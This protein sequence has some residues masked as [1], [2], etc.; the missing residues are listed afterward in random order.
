LIFVSSTTG[1]NSDGCGSEA[2][3]CFSI[4]YAIKTSARGDTIALVAGD[5]FALNSTINVVHDLTIGSTSSSTPACLVDALSTPRPGVL[6]N[7]TGSNA[8]ATGVTVSNIDVS[9]F[10]NSTLF[11]VNTTTVVFKLEN[12]TFHDIYLSSSSVLSF[13]DGDDDDGDDPVS[14]DVDGGMCPHVFSLR[15]AVFRNITYDCSVAGGH[16]LISAKFPANSTVSMVDVSIRDV[17]MDLSATLAP[18]L[19]MPSLNVGIMSLQI[20]N[21]SVVLKNVSVVGTDLMVVVSIYGRSSSEF[22][23]VV[24]CSSLALACFGGDLQVVS[25]ANSTFRGGASIWPALTVV[26][27]GG[28]GQ[29]SGDSGSTRVDIDVDPRSAVG[30]D[31]SLPNVTVTV[32]NTVFVDNQRGAVIYAGAGARLLLESC[33]FENNTSSDRAAVAGDGQ[34][35]ASGQYIVIRDCTF[36][37]NGMTSLTGRGGGALSLTSQDLNVTIEHSAFVDNFAPVGSHVAVLGS[38]TTMEFFTMLVAVHNTTFTSEVPSVDREWLD[39]NFLYVDKAQFLVLNSSVVGP[40]SLVSLS[41]QVQQVVVSDNDSREFFVPPLQSAVM[42]CVPGSFAIVR[43]ADGPHECIVDGTLDA[44]DAYVQKVQ[45]HCKPCGAATY[46]VGLQTVVFANGTADRNETIGCHTCAQGQARFNC[47]G[48]AVGSSRGFWAYT[49]DIVDENTTFSFLPCPTGF[50]CDDKFGCDL[51]NHCS[52][53]RTGVLCGACMAGFTHAL[54]ANSDCVEQLTCSALRVGIGNAIVAALC[55]AFTVY[56]FRRKKKTSDGLEKVA[57]S[58]T[59]LAWIVLAEFRSRD[60]ASVFSE[61]TETVAAV[62]SG[63]FLPQWELLAYCP[64]SE[65]TSLGRLASAAIVPVIL[66][67]CWCL[68][69]VVVIALARRRK[70]SYSRL[71]VVDDNEIGVDAEAERAAQRADPEQPQASAAY[72][73]FAAFLSLFDV[74]L[75]VLVGTF[76]SLLNTVEVPGVGCRLW[77]AG[78]VECSAGIRAGAWCALV[79]VLLLPALFW[80]LHRRSQ[81]SA[82]ALAVEQVNLAPMRKQLSWYN[83]VLIFRRASVAV[84]FSLIQ[85]AGLR[86]LLIRT[87]LVAG[88]ALHMQVLPFA[89]VAI[90]RLESLSLISLLLASVLQEQS[91]GGEDELSA[92]A[93][94][95]TAVLV[96]TFVVLF[97]YEMYTLWFR[98]C[99]RISKPASADAAPQQQDHPES[100]D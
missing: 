12:C 15:S 64:T 46:N 86:A 54:S 4:D 79:T 49:P 44:C 70:T 98:N 87:I 73:A 77:K 91:S 58:F 13:V 41:S 56:V 69:S 93:V 21:A 72:R 99:R 8:T 68:V 11:L 78:D 19:C 32:K 94:L 80:Q 63:A 26:G 88:F 6:F 82:F 66:L 62:G 53:N 9:G 83:A 16:Q 75:F 65:L 3:P 14:M 31:S 51:P 29:F 90:N 39:S 17:A 45:V 5:T 40:A 2:A 42:S 37:N 33:L 36:R 84:V 47:S 95:Q 97:T 71:L 34:S 61:L 43:Q 96:N 92:V 18:L 50:C 22:V 1:H 85:D 52:G 23:D 59:N 20:T 10:L 74:S 81:S 67:V 55:M 48:A 30:G 24:F 89:S 57:V 7:V 100:S 27:A 76:V 25:V 60:S 38:E 35:P 28:L